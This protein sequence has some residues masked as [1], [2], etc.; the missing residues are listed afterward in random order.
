MK[1]AAMAI[2]GTTSRAMDTF[3]IAS[4]AVMMMMLNSEIKKNQ[5]IFNTE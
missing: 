1:A 5:S 4:R 2:N 3:S